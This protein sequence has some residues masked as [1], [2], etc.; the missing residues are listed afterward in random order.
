MDPFH[1]QNASKAAFGW[2]SA[3]N[4]AGELMKDAPQR[5]SRLQTVY[6]FPFN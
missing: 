1:A 2:G 3:R 4:P 5:R 6:T